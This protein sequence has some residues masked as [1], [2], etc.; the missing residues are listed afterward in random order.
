MKRSG[1]FSYCL[2]VFLLATM[3]N[4]GFSQTVADFE[5]FK[6]MP[7]QFLNN[8]SP[9]SSFQSGAIELPNF[10]DAEFNFWSGWSITA[11]T[12]TTTPGFLNQYS[13]IPGE[14]ALQSRT[15]AVGYIYDPIIVRHQPHALGKP[16]IGL[17]I[18]NST[19]AYL[20]M[21]DGDS[22]AKKFG[23]ETGNDPDF[24]LITF[25]KYSGG[26]LSAD[27]I[28]FYLADYRFPN[29]QDD[30]LVSDWAYV[31]LS[32][33][34]PMDSLSIRMT[35]SDNGIFGMNT[36]SYVCIDHLTTDNLQLPLLLN[37]EPDR[38]EIN[39]NPASD[40]II[41]RMPKSGLCTISDIRGTVIWSA[42][43]DAGDQEISVR[44]W[45]AGMYIV[46]VN[47]GVAQKLIIQ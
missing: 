22:F 30:Y 39:P 31:D 25:K 45:P 10:F 38:V 2:I 40:R 35:S 3:A 46:R 17:Y 23:G 11:D 34:G 37:Q 27:S 24:L 4:I 5:N 42:S 29:A 28:D 12:N 33:L 20:S 44:D 36:P 8:A 21:R 26:V 43:F 13:A 41:V 18:T 19:Y 9:E 6:L 14:G 7:G 32:I 16:M 15:Y 1:Q 47:G